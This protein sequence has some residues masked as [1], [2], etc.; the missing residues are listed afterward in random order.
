MTAALASVFFALA[1]APRGHLV[2]RPVNAGAG[3]AA[4]PRPDVRVLLVVAVILRDVSAD[5]P[6]RSAVFNL[7]DISSPR[8]SFSLQR[9]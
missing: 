2:G 1:C 7:H 6:E 8:I 5:L 4:A 9:D 3:V